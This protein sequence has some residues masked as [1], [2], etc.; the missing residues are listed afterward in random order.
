MASP[1]TT[2]P[3]K[4]YRVKEI[5][6]G[7]RRPSEELDISESGTDEA[8]RDRL[9]S[10]QRLRQRL[11][12]LTQKAKTEGLS[13]EE[14]ADLKKLTIH[15]NTVKTRWK[16]PGKGFT[17][18]GLPKQFKFKKGGAVKSSRKKSK[19]IVGIARKGKT[20]AKHR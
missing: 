17:R 16:G 7:G 3:K 9:L 11:F 6:T 15:I 13:D 19:S 5:A 8:T 12:E 10:Q 20:R 14:T 1:K 18:S 2:D 4:F